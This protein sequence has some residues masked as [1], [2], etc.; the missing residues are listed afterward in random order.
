MQ[1]GNGR[2]KD[3]ELYIHIPFCVRKCAYCDFLSAPAE[4]AVRAQYVEALKGEIYQQRFFGEER[5]VTSIFMGGGTPSIL[6]G[7]QIAELLET[8]HDCFRIEEDA[9]ITVE[10]NPGTLTRDKLSCYRQQGVNR[11]SMGLQS[12]DNR[13][14]G[15]LGR[16]HTYEEFLESFA[17]ARKMGFENLNVD[18][19]SAL[20][21]QT[22]ESWQ[23]TLKQ[24]LALKPEH[25]SAY[26]LI[27]EEGAPFY[28][29]FGP[30]AGEE[31][32]LPD[33]DTERR[34][35]Y[36]TGDILKAEGYERYEIS[37]YA[38]PGFA[39]RHNLGYWERKEYLGLGL[40]ASSLMGGVRYRNHKNL[41]AYLAGDYTHEE[42]QR[43]SR[44]EEQEETMFLGLRKTEGVL[45][46]QELMEAYEEVFAK[47]EQQGLL[48]LE[49]GRARLTDLGIDVSNYALAEF[50]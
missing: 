11:L 3:L 14:L 27:I 45:L 16:I 32:L 5:K 15:L 33:E 24:V 50:L 9:E 47:L 7:V 43:L 38:R 30:G 35:Y 40:G 4:E 25:I 42:V 23:R 44:R 6:E 2:E 8:V 39:C 48:V 46:T 21:G 28:E 49:N 36:D 12:A 41:T 10:C 26:S 20:P 31:D 13:E 1:K 22:R 29:R 19:M 18:L 34:M 17:L 37:N